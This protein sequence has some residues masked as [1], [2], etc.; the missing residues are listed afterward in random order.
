MSVT[1]EIVKS[2]MRFV[3]EGRHLVNG[4]LLQR[5]DIVELTVSQVKNFGKKFQP[6]DAPFE[7]NGNLVEQ[8]R[9]E[10]ARVIGEARAEAQQIINDARAE[11]EEI[12]K[13]AQATAEKIVNDAAIETK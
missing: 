11:A 5:G 9:E 12:V 2:A 10:A 1:K 6:A 7:I 13:T 3:G 8:A 4:K